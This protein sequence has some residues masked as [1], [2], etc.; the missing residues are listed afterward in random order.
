MNKDCYNN[1]QCI[2][3]GCMT[4]ALQMANKK[5]E[6][7]CYPPM[8]DRKKW[9]KFKSGNYPI[10]HEGIVWTMDKN[11]GDKPIYTSQS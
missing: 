4:T 1:G 3:C 7:N 5:C 11:E 9:K 6:G 8:M 10:L 2:R